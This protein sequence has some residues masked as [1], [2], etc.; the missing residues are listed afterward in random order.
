MSRISFWFAPFMLVFSA[1]VVACGT[2]DGN[3]DGGNGDGSNG[4]GDG[5]TGSSTT[6]PADAPKIAFFAYTVDGDRNQ[7]TE[8]KTA[9]VERTASFGKVNL[10]QDAM[11]A[12]TSNFN[13]VGTVP[14]ESILEAAASAGLDEVAVVK[15]SFF[16]GKHRLIIQRFRVE[17][18]SILTAD[19]AATSGSSED[20]F[21]R[22]GQRL[23]DRAFEA[24]IDPEAFTDS[25]GYE[26]ARA[27]AE[28]DVRGYFDPQGTCPSAP[29]RLHIEFNSIGVGGSGA[30]GLR[31]RALISFVD[32]Y[33]EYTGEAEGVTEIG[34]VMSVGEEQDILLAT[35][36]NLER[37]RNPT[38]MSSQE[39]LRSLET[40]DTVCP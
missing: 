9:V 38:E 31:D 40:L 19:T 17:T 13:I 2:G 30:S 5:N 28:A 15:M 3:T 12:E 23:A 33:T 6:A 20:S 16:G 26:R 24:E 14:I 32:S 27:L 18:G 22:A 39:F 4:G 34:I 36:E 10:M 35:V 21:L 11:D 7:I 1:L 29:E 25:D 37:A 8:V